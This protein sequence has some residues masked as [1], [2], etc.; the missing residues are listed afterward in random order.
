MAIV[1]LIIAHY[2]QRAHILLCN[3]SKT[4]PSPTEQER[5]QCPLH[6]QQQ[7]VSLILQTQNWCCILIIIS[8]KQER[9]F[10]DLRWQKTSSTEINSH[11]DEKHVV[12]KGILGYWKIFTVNI[13]RFI[14]SNQSHL[15][16]FLV[17]IGKAAVIFCLKDLTWTLS[18]GTSLVL[19]VPRMRS[20]TEHSLT[21]HRMQQLNK[22]CCD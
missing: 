21:V 9:E 14:L 17:V 2:Q 4:Q 1:S 18:L 11:P 20:F 19:R 5:K 7:R 13:G 22:E 15:F 10:S 16:S 6:V 3:F 8:H 12:Q